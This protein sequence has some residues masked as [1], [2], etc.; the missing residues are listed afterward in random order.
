MLAIA[1]L[2]DIAL[3]YYL[4]AVSGEGHLLF[5]AERMCTPSPVS[6]H[7]VSLKVSIKTKPF[8]RRS[9]LLERVVVSSFS[10]VFH[11]FLGIFSLIFSKARYHLKGKMKSSGSPGSSSLS[12]AGGFLHTGELNL[13]NVMVA[14]FSLLQKFF[15]GSPAIF[16]RNLRFVQENISLEKRFVIRLAV[17]CFLFLC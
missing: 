11:T 16:R 15:S 8:F 13:K 10:H 4:V 14:K 12:N 5:L 7:L 2:P 6:F 3:S 1:I 17:K 9:I